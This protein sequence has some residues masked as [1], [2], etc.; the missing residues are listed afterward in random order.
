ME[1]KFEFHL[2]EITFQNIKKKPSPFFI[3]SF[4]HFWPIFP[5]SPATQS[6]LPLLDPFSSVRRFTRPAH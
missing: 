3:L 4:P 1:F 5:C 6:P 2:V